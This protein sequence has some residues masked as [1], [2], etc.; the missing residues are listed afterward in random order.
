M[1]YVEFWVSLLEFFKYEILAEKAVAVLIQM[2]RTFCVKKTFPALLRYSQKEKNSILDIDF[3]M[4]GRIHRAITSLWL[5]C[6]I[7]QE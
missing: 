4:Q 7:T 3:L 5:H 1:T 6:E 2:P